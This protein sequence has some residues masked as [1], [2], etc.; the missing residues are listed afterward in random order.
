MLSICIIVKNEENNLEKCL[1]NI[2]PLGYE[3]I[4][5]DTG[6]TDRTK[7]IALQYTDRVYDFKWCDDFSGARNFAITKATNEY[8]MMLDSDE[9][10]TEVD[11]AELECQILTN[12]E[13][14]GRIHRKNAFMQDGSEFASNE[15][16]NRIFPKSIYQ[17][18]G[19][20]HE[21]IVAVDKRA[22][23]TYITSVY[24]D[25]GGYIG[26]KEER[27]R[28]AERNIEL[29]KKELVDKGEDPYVL[30]QLG[31]GYYYQGDYVIA[32]FYFDKA[33]FFDLNTKLE[34]VIDM[35]EM[36]GYSLM[37]SDQYAKALSLEN[38]YKEFS[39]SCDFVFLMGL[40]YMENA[41]FDKAVKELKKATAFKSCKVEG[42]SSFLANYNIGVI[43]ECLGNK[44][45]A[46][47][48]YMKC[49]GY[50]KAVEALGRLE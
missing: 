7:E 32:V 13:A 37:R 14:V 42:A 34:Y 15:L 30:Y 10:L 22:Y 11:K 18:E 45:L 35:V 38:V 17:Y 21:Q 44:K 29:L 33:L 31:K 39:N 3:I 49:K 46:E 5:V 2:R 6:S 19:R 48:Y 25:H 23:D 27:R 40:I 12:K 43:Y 8:I 41:M 26:G 28:K 50:G 24:T 9:F 36:Y 4:V 47:S 20:I 16:V 1:K